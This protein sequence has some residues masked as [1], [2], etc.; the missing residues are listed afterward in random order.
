MRRNAYDYK[1]VPLAKVLTKLRN[2]FHDESIVKSEYERIKAMREEARVGRIKS[3]HA[4]KAWQHLLTPLNREIINAKVCAAYKPRWNEDE[5]SAS[6]AQRIEAWS[7]YTSVLMVLRRKFNAYAQEGKTPAQLFK[8]R[9]KTP[10]QVAEDGEHWA[11]WVPEHI[12]GELRRVFGQLPRVKF[13]K[14]KE[15]FERKFPKASLRTRRGQLQE[16][17]QKEQERHERALSALRVMPGMSEAARLEV[18]DLVQTHTLLLAMAKEAERR[19]HRYR[20]TKP[21]PAFWSGLFSEEE[22]AQ[23]KYRPPKAPKI[24]HDELK[25]KLIIKKKE[26]EQANNDLPAWVNT[27]LDE[28]DEDD[29]E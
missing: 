1:G 18:E 19:L 13:A 22:H 9:L 10:N 25:A 12:K 16:A 28:D 6:A 8:E 11:D 24:D 3:T 23:Y 26:P 17:I 4:K 20:E 2:R 15:P 21:L 14:S 27:P 29:D 5:P 7:A